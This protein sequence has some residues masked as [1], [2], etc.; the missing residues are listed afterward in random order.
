MNCPVAEMLSSLR[1]LGSFAFLFQSSIFLFFL[2]L[3]LQKFKRYSQ[4]SLISD[5]LYINFCAR[6]GVVII[7]CF[8]LHLPSRLLLWFQGSWVEGGLQQ[9]FNSWDWLCAFTDK[10]LLHPCMWD[11]SLSFSSFSCC[12]EIGSLTAIVGWTVLDFLENQSFHIQH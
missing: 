11:P 5:V 2:N 7:V 1:V 10:D 12:T 4:V 9:V 8:P 3:P 6:V